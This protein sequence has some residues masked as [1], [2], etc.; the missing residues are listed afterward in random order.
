MKLTKSGRI[1]L[2]G[3]EYD[4]PLDFPYPAKDYS[5]GKEGRNTTYRK[6]W[7]ERYLLDVNRT[8]IE[9]SELKVLSDGRA[10]LDGIALSKDDS[11]SAA[12]VMDGLKVE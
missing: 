7:L 1:E 4:N 5:T 9:R 6:A 11:K 8:F 2:G 10:F 3:V 12:E